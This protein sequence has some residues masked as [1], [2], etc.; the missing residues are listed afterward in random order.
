[1]QA[2][3]ADTFMKLADLRVERDPGQQVGQLLDRTLAQLSPVAHPAMEF[4]TILP[5][6]HVPMP[7]L[8]DLAVRR[9]PPVSPRNPG[10]RWCRTSRDWP[11]WHL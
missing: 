7:W 4:V 8:R 10:T 5:A 1:M 9:P 2:N 11:S 6:S 3:P